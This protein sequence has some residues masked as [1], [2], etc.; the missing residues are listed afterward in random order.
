MTRTLVLGGTAWLGHEI[1]TQLVARGVDVTCLARG[2]SGMAPEGATLIRADRR[3]ADAYDAVKATSW[4]EIIELSYEVGLVTGAL[5]ALSSTARHWT[6]ISS[7]SV[8][9]SNGEPG[10]DESAAVF[11]PED[12]D[13]Y[14]HAKV[15]AER[16]SSAAL[17]D[18]LLIARPGLI[19]G[20]GDTSD[21]FGY[22]VA[23]FAFAQQEPVLVPRT[24]GR[25]VQMIDLRDL[26][27]WVVAAGHEG[28]TGIY[29]VVGEQHELEGVLATAADIAGYTGQRVPAD[30][31]W[32]TSHDVNYWAGPRSL[33]LRLP[34]SDIA[35]AQRSNKRYLVAGGRER[36][37]RGTLGDMLTDERTRGLDRERRSGLTRVEELA[38]IGELLN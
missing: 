27:E 5:D 17:G 12:L 26:A 32:L 24:E 22:W 35:F 34:T 7:V 25:V 21:R 2:A 15:A 20:P 28:T 8:Y 31:D 33:P 3:T 10:A 37:M 38:L 9:T 6:L 19:A 30:D 16:A 29:N 13:N 14:A 18:R 11:E 1:A 36:S 23:R 4:D